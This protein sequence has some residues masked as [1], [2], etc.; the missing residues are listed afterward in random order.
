MDLMATMDKM[1]CS[2][3]DICLDEVW[4]S[5]L[6]QVGKI[7]NISTCSDFSSK[8]DKIGNR[9]ESMSVFEFRHTYSSDMY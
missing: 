9:S 8:W 5:D 6:Q 1:A 3:S 4:D 2:P 7:N